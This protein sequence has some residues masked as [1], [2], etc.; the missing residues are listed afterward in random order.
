MADVN[1]VYLSDLL[2]V[3]MDLISVQLSTA[4]TGDRLEEDDNDD[5]IYIHCDA[6]TSQPAPP[7]G[8]YFRDG[9]T[10]IGHSQ[11]W[12]IKSQNVGLHYAVFQH[13]FCN[14]LQSCMSNVP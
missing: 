13:G 2:C 3:L 12:S 6:R 10:K 8:N 4:A 7:V 14:S 11:L 5:P 1:V 9:R